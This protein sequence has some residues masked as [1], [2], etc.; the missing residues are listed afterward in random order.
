MGR[1][2]SIVSTRVCQSIE[3]TKL[4]RPPD[5]CQR[6]DD[7]DLLVRRELT[8]E[9]FCAKTER[10]RLQHHP[11]QRRSTTIHLG[12]LH[13]PAS[14]RCK[15]TANSNRQVDRWLVQC[16][17]ISEC[18]PAN[19]TSNVCGCFTVTLFTPCERSTSSL[20][21]ISLVVSLSFLVD[22]LLPCSEDSWLTLKGFSSSDFAQVAEPP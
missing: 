3:K 1:L 17:Y 8:L 22:G 7:I 4:K 14:S 10:P 19:Q 12:V 21:E 13:I 6:F 2:F 11:P 9:W 5:P 20:G 16:T 18:V 15:D